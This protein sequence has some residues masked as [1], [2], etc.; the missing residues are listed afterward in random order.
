MKGIKFF[1]TGVILLFLILS[2]S[3]VW[4]QTD[5]VGFSN[6]SSDADNWGT[7]GAITGFSFQPTSDISVT[8]LGFFD[9]GRDGLS[10]DH[11]VGIF[12]STYKNLGYTTVPSMSNGGS[13]YFLYTLLLSPIA[14]S[15]G[16]TYYILGDTGSEKYTWDTVG[17]YMAADINYLSDA[18][19]WGY[20]DL[21]GDIT[22]SVIYADP[23][24]DDNGIF[25]P[26][27]KYMPVPIPSAVWLLS[28]GL[29]GL[30]GFR[31]RNRWGRN[32]QQLEG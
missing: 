2:T 18:S 32:R 22:G 4:A 27:F 26:N 30:L 1:V 11:L 7:A 29:I 19:I 13:S 6:P 17:F 23:G 31:N 3:M 28:S 10:G 12:D 15:S 16:E 14:L 20:A 24:V 5:A 21:Q 9:A 8:H 25:G